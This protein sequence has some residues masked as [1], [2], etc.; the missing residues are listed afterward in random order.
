MNKEQL[1]R[2]LIE[3]AEHK[4]ARVNEMDAYELFDR[5][6]KWNGIC[7]YTSDIIEAFKA[8]FEDEILFDDTE[9]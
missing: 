2:Y 8:A 5:Y 6:L 9:D 1:K 4:E 3:E 7:G